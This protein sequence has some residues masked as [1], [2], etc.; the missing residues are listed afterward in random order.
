MTLA[1]LI[2][3]YR[4]PGGDDS[5]HSKLVGELLTYGPVSYDGTVWWFEY[6]RAGGKINSIDFEDIK[7]AESIELES[8]E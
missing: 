6:E 5:L 3:A 7:D 8:E 2:E 1:E 4:G